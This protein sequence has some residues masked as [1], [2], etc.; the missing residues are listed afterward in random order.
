ML[1][2]NY[3]K[4]TIAGPAGLNR[5]DIMYKWA[6]IPTIIS[7]IN[8]GFKCSLC[9]TKVRLKQRIKKYKEGSKLFVTH[10][11]CFYTYYDIIKEVA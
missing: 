1:P 11:G 2:K 8:C 6:E 9:H 5:A 3:D 4:I 7:K 10:E